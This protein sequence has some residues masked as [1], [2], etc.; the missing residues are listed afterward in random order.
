MLFEEAFARDRQKSAIPSRPLQGEECR[1]RMGAVC[2]VCYGSQLTYEQEWPLKAQAFETWWKGLRRPVRPDPLKPSPM[3]RYYRVVSKRKVYTHQNHVRLGLVDVGRRKPFDVQL[4][5]IEPLPHAA[6][7]RHLAGL[8]DEP[9]YRNLAAAMSHV[10]VK[11]NYE[12]FTVILNVRRVSPADV[13]AA[14]AL[15]KAVSKKVPGIVGFFLF[16]GS[17]DDYYMESRGSKEKA[18]HKIYGKSEI[19]GRFMARPFL[20]SPVCFTQVNPGVAEAM[21]LAAGQHLPLSPQASLFDLYCGYGLF[22]LCLAERVRGVTGVEMSPESIHAAEENARRQKVPN[23]RFQVRTITGGT[24][25]RIMAPCR[26][27]DVVLLDPPRNGPAAGVVEGIVQAGPA[28]VCHIFCNVDRL[29]VDLRR[30]EAGG[31]VLERVLPMDM[32]PGTPS[33]EVMAF[34]RRR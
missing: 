2:P 30:W 20:F 28:A 23:A 7:Y 18:L 3:G 26:E 9:S 8:L 27:G 11:G 22:S 17:D 6:I 4:C 33:L 34:L 19:F 12:E 29:D 1:S 14:N 31:Y 21:V 10:I 25:A 24:I 32:F 13:Q 16:E 15:S 5:A